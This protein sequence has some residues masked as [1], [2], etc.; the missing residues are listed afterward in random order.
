MF[1]AAVL[2]AAY[3]ARGQRDLQLQID[4]VQVKQQPGTTPKALERCH[5]FEL[6]TRNN[7]N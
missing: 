2:E 7:I 1:L 4:T 3:I 6:L 5:Y